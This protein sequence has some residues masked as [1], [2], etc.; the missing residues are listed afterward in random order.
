MKTEDM[1]K[2]NFLDLVAKQCFRD[3]ADRD[4]IL[5]RISHQKELYANYYWCGLQAFEK[6]IKSILIEV[7]Y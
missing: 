6:Y 2:D 4:Y 1:S 7:V 3:P 5:A